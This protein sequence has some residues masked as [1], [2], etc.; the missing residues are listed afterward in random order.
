MRVTQHSKMQWE[1]RCRLETKHI[2]F[3]I[4]LG[5]WIK[6][7]HQIKINPNTKENVN[8]GKR[9]KGKVADTIN[10]GPRAAACGLSVDTGIAFVSAPFFVADSTKG[11]LIFLHVTLYSDLEV[12]FSLKLTSIKCLFK[13]YYGVGRMKIFR[14]NASWWRFSSV[15]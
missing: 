10:H 7:T 8:I 2:F 3:I 6:N 12:N 11:S 1:R 15:I 14:N 5:Q 13:P 4:S 9:N